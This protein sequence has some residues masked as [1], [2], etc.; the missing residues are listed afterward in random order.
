MASNLQLMPP[1]LDACDP[2][3]VREYKRREVLSFA[4]M[5]SLCIYGLVEH[6]WQDHLSSAWRCSAY[7][8]SKRLDGTG[9]HRWSVWLN[10]MQRH[11]SYEYPVLGITG[12]AWLR[13]MMGQLVFTDIRVDLLHGLRTEQK[14]FNLDGYRL[15]CSSSQLLPRLWS[16]YCFS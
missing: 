4:F 13:H 16:P 3:G 6:E 11:E 9:R 12:G 14:R 8:Q 7:G 5:E 1:T 15:P 10:W 2:G